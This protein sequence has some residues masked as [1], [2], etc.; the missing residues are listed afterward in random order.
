MASLSIILGEN[1]N[2]IISYENLSFLNNLV[3]EDGL[4]MDESI[5]YILDL[6]RDSFKKSNEG[7]PGEP[8]ILKEIDFLQVN[9]EYLKSGA[10]TPSQYELKLKQL[11]IKDDILY[12]KAIKQ[13]EKRVKSFRV[14]RIF[15]MKMN[16]IVIDNP[17]SFLLKGVISN[18]P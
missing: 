11:Y 15:S 5:N 9:I 14:D 10:K 4:S 17:L 8:K 16:E 18:N 6:G 7:K 2:C 3:N 12:I 1:V 13:G